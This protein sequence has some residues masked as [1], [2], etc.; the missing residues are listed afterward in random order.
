[1]KQ[2]RLQTHS[3]AAIDF[4][5]NGKAYQ[6]I[7]G[8]TLASALLAN[9]VDVVGRSF[10]YARPRGIFGHGAEEPNGIIQLGRGAGTVPNLKATQVEL[11]QGL[12]ASSVNGWPSVDFDVMGLIGAFGRLMPPG[13]YYK[14]FM[15]PK[16]LWMTY[17]HFIRKAAGLGE[18]PKEA[19]PDSYDKLNQHCD[20]LVV[21]AGPAGLVAAREAARTGAR[22]IIADEQAQFGGSLLASKQEVDGLPASLWVASLVAELMVYTNVQMLPRSTVFGYYDHN[23]LTILERRTDH[24]GLSSDSGT[25]QRMHRVRAAQVVLAAGAFERPL[26]FAHND[27]PGVMLAS[28]VSTYVNRY[29]VAPG[30]KLVV[31]TTNDNAYQT[32]LDWHQ[33]G[34]EIVAVVDTRPNLSGDIVAVVKALGIQV[35]AGHGLIEAQGSKRVTCALVAPINEAGTHVTGAV[36]RL[37]CDLIACSGGWSPA[38]HLSSHTGAKPEWDEDIVGFRPGNSKQQERSAGACRGTFDLTGCLSEGAS[39]GAQAAMLSG[40]GDGNLQFPAIVVDEYAQ[41]PQQALFLVPHTKIPSRAPSQFVDFQL[42]VS[43]SAIELAVREGFESV[44]HVKRYTA[45]GFGTDQGKLGNINGMAILANALN[46][47]IAET[48]TTIFRPSY[49]PTTFGAI[50]GRDVNSLFDPTRFT[51]VHRWHVEQGAEFED[52]GQWKR[53]WYFPKQDET[54]RQAVDREGLAVR[55]SV[56]ILDASTLGKIDV[57]GPDAAE[58]IT[59][60]YTNSYLKLAPGKCRYGVMLKEDGMIFDDGVCACLDD[61]HYLIFTTT[62]GAAGV[63]AWLELWQQT[64]WPELQVYFTSVTDHWTTATVTGPNARKVIAKVCSDIDLSSDAFSFMDWREGTVAG[65]KARVFRISFTGELSYEV[66]V[67]AHYGRHVWEA[68]IAAGKEFNITPY[69]TETMHVL[70]AEK[71]FIIVGQDTDGSMTPADM[72]MD[73]VVGKNKAFSFIGKRSLLRSDTVR[74]DRKQLVGLK[75]LNDKAVLPEGAQVVFD[76]KQKIPMA[77][78]GHVTSSYYSACLGHSIALAVIKGG[79]E[80]LGQVVHCPLADGRSIASEIVSSVFYDPQGERHHV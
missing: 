16:K 26:V 65:V 46:Q 30:H 45:L 55:H 68:L 20:V 78:Q 72:N 35:I 76:A 67:P 5:F 79:H 49:T 19:D 21:G 62:G 57:Q 42:D 10:K 44:E 23:F 27:I 29:G 13:F 1:M 47:T 2:N 3:G 28:S 18:T 17:E 64:E 38:V 60:M 52:V 24:L 73:W 25:R 36:Q 32:A 54:M 43:A 8:D 50:A 77:M 75:P 53:P 80:R 61:N 9:G 34:R 40:H 71:G 31:F 59:R 12:E 15:Y 4:T 7:A 22:V 58:F 41:Q 37:A 6:G 70:R 66:N 51:A 33:T 39:A 14:T 11:Y 56:G 48:G 69:G 63:L 74:G